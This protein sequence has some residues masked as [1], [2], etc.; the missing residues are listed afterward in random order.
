[1]DQKRS[2]CLPTHQR[3]TSDFTQGGAVR[4]DCDIRPETTNLTSSA[5]KLSLLST[6]TDQKLSRISEKQFFEGKSSV[7][8]SAFNDDAM[9]LDTSGFDSVFSQAE[10]DLTNPPETPIETK[11]LAT[12]DHY[13]YDEADLPPLTYQKP[14]K[15]LPTPQS[16]E[17]LKKTLRL[18][19]SQDVHEPRFTPQLDKRFDSVF[20]HE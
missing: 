17:L 20:D 3:S 9:M 8:G 18:D 12:Q 1:M 7:L 4:L 2:P 19:L 14:F 11:P 10:T 5:Y 6:T 15:P 13:V 16:K